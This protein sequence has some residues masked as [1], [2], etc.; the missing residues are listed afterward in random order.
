MAKQWQI[1][2]GTE[3][4][5]NNFTG[6]L[7][8][9]TM[10]TTNNTLRVHDGVT[11]GGHVIGKSI[12][13]WNDITDK[14]STFTPSPHTHGISDI[15]NFP[16]LANVATTGSYNDLSNKPTIPSTASDVSALP[17]TTKYG[18]SIETSIDPSTFVLTVDLKDQDGNILGNSQEIDLPLETI[19]VNGR[20]DSANKKVILTLVN[21][22]TIEF[23]IA[24]LVSGLQPEI[25]S[26]NKLDADLIKDGSVNVVVTTNDKNNWNDKVDS[27]DLAVVATSGDYNDLS[28]K[29]TIPAAQV[30]TDWNATSGMGVILNKPSTFA[31][32]AHNHTVSEI[33]DFP[34]LATVAT[35]GS[36]QDLTDKPSI[37]SGQIQSDWEQTSDS[38]VDFIKNKPTIP[39]KTSD[40]TNDSGYLTNVA[41]NDIDNKPST[42]TPSSHTHDV[43]DITNFPILATV[44]TSGD[45]DDLSNKPT[46]P[47]AQVQTDWNATTGMASILNKPTLSTVATSGSYNDLSNKPSIPTT[48][49]DVSAL[50]DTTKYGASLSLSI[51]DTTYIVTATLKDQS[52]NTLGTA[53]TIDLPL[54]S[55]VVSGRYDS[56]NKKVILT[57]K[58]GSE[59]DFSVA[60]LISGLQTEIT[61]ANKLNA[62]LID[63]STSTNK[64]VLASDKTNWNSKVD[65]SSLA[66]VATSGSYNDLT[67]KPTIPAG[68]VNSDWNASS[69]VAQILNKPE[70]ATVATS[71]NYNDLS[72]KPTIPTVPT[73]VSAFNND[74]GYL[75]EIDWDDINNKPSTFAPSAHNHTVSEISDFPTLATVATSGNYNDLSNK[76]TIPAAQVN[77]DWNA[78]SGVSQILNKPSTFTPSA[79]NHTVSEI[80]DFPTLSIVATSGDYEDLSNTPT[81]FT[82]TDG[83]DAGTQGLVPAPAVTDTN[84]YLKA[85][86]TWATVEATVTGI[87]CGVL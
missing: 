86:G 48:A 6:A 81:N 83:T 3:S 5:N 47:A 27:E 11:Q 41:W 65:A 76:P 75:T 87:D 7:G 73:N 39:T 1:R 30:Q 61:S 9:V 54:E 22:E 85:D 51:D 12:S 80:T 2:R 29:P 40:L 15:T 37:P 13:S 10:D 72:N 34:T 52:G 69:G 4:E 46:I 36:Y 74:A 45:Y 59:I 8:E 43:S 23:S 21:G 26:T 33:T 60:D 82:G 24:D 57:L 67:D 71:G 42:F 28:N 78:T 63:D 19:V 64:F 79:H 68:Q 31:P 25:T 14:P 35:S 44:A 38:E 77:S 84:K 56:V 17:D 50:P 18:A 58:D 66:T 49:S 70:L 55:V 53:Q 62:D 20:Y 16:E 32:S